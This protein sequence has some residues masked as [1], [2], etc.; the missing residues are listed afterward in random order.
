[1]CKSI[2][3]EDFYIASRKKTP[4]LSQRPDGFA[5]LELSDGDKVV[6]EEKTRNYFFALL[7]G[8]G[9]AS[10][11]QNSDDISEKEQNY[12]PPEANFNILLKPDIRVRGG[13]ML[14]VSA[15]D[16]FTFRA[17]KEVRA[18]VFAFDFLQQDFYESFLTQGNEKENAGMPR[19]YKIQMKAALRGFWEGAFYLLKESCLTL[20]MERMKRRELFCILR[21]TLRTDDALSFLAPLV[22]DKNPFRTLVLSNYKDGINVD[23]LVKISGMCRTN[24]YSSFKK[25]FGMSVYGWMQ[26][27]RASSVLETV[28][29]QGMNVKTMMKRHHFVSGSNFIRF[30][31]KYYKCTPKELLRHAQ[32]EQVVSS[33]RN[34]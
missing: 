30:C 3:L 19:K 26:M 25:E 11:S 6:A 15:G 20:W 8:G 31:K 32:E 1:M 22:L 27:R 12:P 18:V 2:R 9:E 14:F 28:S 29:E 34:K 33:V 7:K 21:H 16:R 17:T 13:E 24:F 4:V 10:Y 23:Y 5:A